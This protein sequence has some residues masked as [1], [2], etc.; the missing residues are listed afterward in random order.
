M[1]LDRRRVPVASPEDKRLRMRMAALTGAAYHAHGAPCPGAPYFLRP[2]SLDH[3]VEHLAT[4][5]PH[6]QFHGAAWLL[7]GEPHPER[8][9]HLHDAAQRVLGPGM[10]VK[11]LADHMAKET[12]ANPARSRRHGKRCAK[13][14]EF[15]HQKSAIGC[16]RR[17]FELS[18]DQ[19]PAT[20]ITLV[21]SQIEVEKPLLSFQTMA[22]PQDWSTAAPLFWTASERVTDVGGEFV[23]VPNLPPPGTVSYVAKL[24]EEIITLGLNPLFPII[25]TNILTTTYKNAGDPYGFDVNLYKCV[26]TIIGGSAGPGGIDVDAGSL[27]LSSVAGA[28]GWTRMAATKRVR[29][30]PREMCGWEL[31]GWLNLFAPYVIGAFIGVLV[32]EG[33]CAP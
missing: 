32:Y 23:P 20:L 26:S 3:V 22:D 16:A 15:L 25:G 8:T 6:I 14:L 9:K 28:P 18:I 13:G 24:L 31:G 17:N 30:T 27:R 4:E 29:F 2:L 19:D 7:D 5:E 11:D 12:G 33:A 1:G 10:K 21:Q